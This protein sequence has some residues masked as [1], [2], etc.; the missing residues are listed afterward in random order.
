MKI[1]NACRR[2]WA[3][4]AIG[5]TVGAAPAI[6]QSDKGA[7]HGHPGAMQPSMDK[8]E[9]AK[10]GMSGT[11]GGDLHASMMT[12]MKGMQS[13]KATGDTDRDFATMMKM[14]H[15]A[16]IDMAQ[17]ELKTGKDPKMKAMAQR[18]IAAQQKEIEEFDNWLAKGR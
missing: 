14:H 13:M 9:A 5:L 10:P 3:A 17:V 12:S 1:P 4:A 11:S 2:V 18:I 8:N 6:A 16:A 15:Q 7:P